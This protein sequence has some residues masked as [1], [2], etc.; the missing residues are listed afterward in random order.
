MYS[1]GLQKVV[2]VIVAI[3]IFSGMYAY[4]G[5]A[6]QQL[7]SEGWSKDEPLF[8]YETST[9]YN[10]FFNR[11][12][13]YVTLNDELNIIYIDNAT[14][15]YKVYSKKL[16]FIKEGQLMN[17]TEPADQI[18]VTAYGNYFE[19]IVV[20]GELFKCYQFNEA[21]KITQ[22]YELTIDHPNYH[23]SNSHI[24]LKDDDSLQLVSSKGPVLLKMPNKPYDI[25]NDVKYNDGYTV[26]YLSIIDG[27]RIVFKDTYNDLGELSKTTKIAPL[28]AD[29]MRLTPIDFQVYQQGNI[30]AYKINIKDMKFGTTYLNFFRY[31]MTKNEVI[32]SQDYNELQDRT[33]LIS[34]HEIIGL[35]NHEPSAELLGKTYYDFYNVMKYDLETNTL[36]PL[37]KTYK[38]PREYIYLQG[39]D[40][41][42]L[43]WG[44]LKKGQMTVRISSNDPDYIAA[45]LVLTSERLMDIFYETIDVFMK[46]PTYIIITG[47]F[48]LAVTM[49]IVMPCYMLFV[50]FFEKH[51]LKVFG[52]LIVLHNISKL[53][54]HSQFTSRIILPDILMTYTIPFIVLT[55][56]LGI[57][58]YLVATHHRR[59]DNPIIAYIPFF[60]TDVLFHTFIF[61]PFIMMNL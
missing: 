60:I 52:I 4:I 5:K 47:V 19:M 17:L 58:S 40:Y 44:E 39:D 38:G 34:T 42:Y 49:V 30:E 31:D 55:N 16:K 14:I 51:Y 35:F 43:I 20:S 13:S 45:S 21:L 56:I 9:E 7:P 18:Y 22:T 2:F 59:F 41:D 8:S 25:I 50:T 28:L 23:I 3:L 1:K 15:K 6:Y 33:A 46:I 57:Y 10:S 26:Y 61:G 48:I 12:L 36:K 27:E 11:Q 29:E 37:T 54:I 32:F 53:I 24:I